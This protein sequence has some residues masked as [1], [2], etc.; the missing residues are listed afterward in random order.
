MRFYLCTYLG[1]CTETK[2]NQLQFMIPI[3]Q[4]IFLEKQRYFHNY[5]LSSLYH[6]P[7]LTIS[8]IT[9]KVIFNRL[10][11]RVKISKKE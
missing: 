3:K 4:Q 11:T 7:P 1:F 10:G 5:K 9:L 8:K 2:V 6:I